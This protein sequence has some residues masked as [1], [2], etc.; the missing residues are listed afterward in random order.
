MSKEEKIKII[1][2]PLNLPK[3]VR[4][5]IPEAQRDYEKAIKRR[6]ILVFLLLFI[7]IAIRL[8]P[9]LD[10]SASKCSI[11]PVISHNDIKYL[12]EGACTKVIFPM[13]VFLKSSIRS[14]LSTNDSLLKFLISLAFSSKS[15]SS[16][17]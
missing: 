1:I 6:I 16:F 12:A 15:L 13:C 5:K 2:S 14:L 3:S 8:L 4:E 11:N 17:V 7:L 9:L 10:G